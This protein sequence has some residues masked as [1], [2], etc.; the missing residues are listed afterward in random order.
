M[1]NDPRPPGAR[2]HDAIGSTA[3]STAGSTAGS[4]D[5]FALF[6]TPVVVHQL[7][8]PPDSRPAPGP[9]A[10]DDPTDDLDGLNRDIADIL[11]A[12]SRE[13]P[14]IQRSNVGGWH[15]V[16]DLGQRP[17]RCFRALIGLIVQ[18][19]HDT[20]ETLASDQGVALQTS[21]RF[22][23]QGWAMVMQSGDYTITHDHATA[24]WSTAYYVDAGDADPARFPESGLLA[25]IDPR[26]G[27]PAIP[28]AD[29]FPSTF[30]VRPRTGSLVIF[31]GPLQHY[32]H[33]YRGQRPRICISCNLRMEPVTPG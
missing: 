4:I 30:T 15:S 11:L 17:D 21:Y 2:P 22:A 12:E 31:P 29:L 27:A 16:P 23:V 33:P 32:V 7:G 3:D 1:A 26:R 20:V 18:R 9:D 28:G 13:V 6:A 14:G 8:D 19:V 25:F 24:H 5:R 10:S